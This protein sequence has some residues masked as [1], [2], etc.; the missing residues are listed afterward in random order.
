MDT[1]LD[2]VG[3]PEPTHSSK[4]CMTR[5]EW[6]LGLPVPDTELPIDVDIKPNFI[7]Q[8]QN[9]PQEFDVM[10]AVFEWR[11]KSTCR[12]EFARLLKFRLL[13]SNTNFLASYLGFSQPSQLY[14]FVDYI[15]PLVIH[16]FISL[17]ARGDFTYTHKLPTRSLL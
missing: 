6:L 8:P 12:P 9:H 7:P 4:A 5:N 10:E 11:D 16:P 3:H 1:A 15:V 13:S 17:C 2:S 14:H